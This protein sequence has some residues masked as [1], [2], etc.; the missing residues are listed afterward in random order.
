MKNVLFICTGNTC[1]SP[2]AE[3]IFRELLREKGILDVECSSCGLYAGL[4]SPATG[5][6][7]RAA[8]AYG[9]DISGH[10]SCPVSKYLLDRSDL[11]VCLT[12]SH[13]YYLTDRYC[14]PEEKLRA[15]DI[16]D[17]YEGDDEEYAQCASEIHDA[18]QKLLSD[19]FF[20]TEQ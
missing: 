20:L 18:L 6:A 14:V 7:V 19:K 15:L 8:K 1:R 5:R 2:M 11:I 13:K 3:G 10:K 17:P 16:A 12:D 4:H 9:A